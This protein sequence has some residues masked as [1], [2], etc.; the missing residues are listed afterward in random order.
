MKA[1][2]SFLALL[3]AAVCVY[4]GGYGGGHYG[5]KTVA[6]PHYQ[7]YQQ[8]YRPAYAQYSQY[9]AKPAYAQ[10]QYVQPSYVA[11]GGGQGI[12]FGGGSGNLFG[13]SNTGSIIPIIII[14]VLL[15][16]FAPLLI[17]SLASSNEAFYD[18]VGS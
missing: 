6:Y 8:F 11:V 18:S 14:F 12:G 10:L 16:I 2:L 7:Q 15:A 4:A 13:G 5:G 9:Y 3:G 17:A 1:V